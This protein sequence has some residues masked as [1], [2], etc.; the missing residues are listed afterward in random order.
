[1]VNE[2]A[3]GEPKKTGGEGIGVCPK[4]FVPWVFV[5]IFRGRDVFT[6]REAYKF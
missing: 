6:S 5:R 2:M 3:D 4:H 1:M